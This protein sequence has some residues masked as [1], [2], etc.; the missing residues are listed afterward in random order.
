VKDT[1]GTRRDGK[2]V[3]VGGLLDRDKVVEQGKRG[4][5]LEPPI[6]L[7]VLPIEERDRMSKRNKI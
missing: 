1:S 7:I 3:D 2:K 4:R 6:K 5:E